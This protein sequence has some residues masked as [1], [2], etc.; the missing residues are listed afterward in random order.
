MAA[1]PIG[2]LTKSVV[3]VSPVPIINILGLTKPLLLYTPIWEHFLNSR[4]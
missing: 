3:L 4:Y 1:L 2:I